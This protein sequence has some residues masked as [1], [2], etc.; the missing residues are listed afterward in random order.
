MNNGNIFELRT[1]AGNWRYLVKNLERFCSE[2]KL[3]FFKNKI[4]TSIVDPAHVAMMELN[5]YDSFFTNFEVKKDVEAAFDVG[6]LKTRLKGVKSNIEVSLSLEKNWTFVMTIHTPYGDI[7]KRFFSMDPESMPDPK[8]PRLSL[9]K[10]SVNP[11]AVRT[12]FPHIAEISDHTRWIADAEK[13]TISAE[14]DTVVPY[15]PLLPALTKQL[16]HD[17]RKEIEEQYGRELKNDVSLKIDCCDSSRKKPNPHVKSLFN[18]DYM[19]TALDAI[20]GA[21]N[22]VIGLGDDNPI[23]L[24]FNEHNGK[25]KFLDGHILIAPRIESE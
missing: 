5:L 13:L 11:T 3:K 8:I 1:K 23:A 15:N 24:I 2:A 6:S 22:L 14:G 9:Y 25:K 21:D 20:K 17:N 4:Q 16:T 10:F 12:V 19:Q 18:S 7:Q